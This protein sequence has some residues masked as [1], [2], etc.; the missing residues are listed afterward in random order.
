V[1]KRLVLPLLALVCLAPA[2]LQQPKQQSQNQLEVVEAKGERQARR[3][4]LDGR[5]KNTGQRVLYRLVLFFDLIDPEQKVI[6]RLKGPIE[7]DVLEPGEEASFHFDIPDQ[8]RAMQFRMG[9][10]SE[11]ATDFEVIKPGPYPI[12]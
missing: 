8:A 12:D 7:E 4:M 11:K 10:A 2:A 5:V 6:S 9:A 3:I 1:T